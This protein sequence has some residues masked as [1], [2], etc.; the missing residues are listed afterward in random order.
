MMF[1]MRRY[2]QDLFAYLLQRRAR[3]AAVK[4]SIDAPVRD[5]ARSRLLV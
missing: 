1:F 4:K 3:L 2:Y 5:R